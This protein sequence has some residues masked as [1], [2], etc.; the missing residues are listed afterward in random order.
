[1][2]FNV[3]RRNKSL[4]SQNKLRDRREQ[5]SAKKMPPSADALLTQAKELYYSQTHLDQAIALFQQY[6]AHH[7]RHNDSLYLCAVSLLH[8][9]RPDDAIEKLAAISEDYENK[10]NALLLAAMAFNKLGTDSGT[11]ATWGGVWRR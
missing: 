3:H 2:N 6:L 7:P 1:M 8:L 9:G 4:F 11:Q 5:K 10:P